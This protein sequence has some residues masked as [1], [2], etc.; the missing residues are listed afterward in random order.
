MQYIELFLISKNFEMSPCQTW[1]GEKTYKEPEDLMRSNKTE[2]L[3]SILKKEIKCT[4][5]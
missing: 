4:I 1:L 5:S 3:I 2:G